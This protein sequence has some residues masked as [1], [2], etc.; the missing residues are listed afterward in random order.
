MFTATLLALNTLHFAHTVVTINSD[1]L[2]KSIN[3]LL[4]IMATV[5]VYSRS[6]LG[7]EMLFRFIAG[8]RRIEV[9]LVNPRGPCLWEWG[10]PRGLTGACREVR[11]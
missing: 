9:P 6:E 4:Y 10:I 11:F 7:L 2:H 5:S 8:F 3:R 1:Y